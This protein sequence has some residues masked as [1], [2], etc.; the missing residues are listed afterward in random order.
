M[1]KS[2]QEQYAEMM[3]MK[4]NKAAKDIIHMLKEQ[5]LDP[6]ASVVSI[7]KASA[8]IIESFAMMGG[9]ADMLEMMIKEMIGPARQEARHLMAHVETKD[10]YNN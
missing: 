8:I 9:N 7:L 6:Q 5:G 2:E 1:K 4:T 10:V 3:E